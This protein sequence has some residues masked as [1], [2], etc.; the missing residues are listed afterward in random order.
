M[1]HFTDEEHIELADA[2][3]IAPVE[4]DG[5][6]FATQAPR[7]IRAAWALREAKQRQKW[8]E[9]RQQGAHAVASLEEVEALHE[10]RL[11]R[12][13]AKLTKTVALAA[14]VMPGG[15]VEARLTRIEEK[16]AELLRR[17]EPA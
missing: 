15:S 4:K 14:T 2:L 16:L 1:L 5:V 7:F 8:Q 13:E 3:G 10:T 12:I 17:T 9:R 6:A 11:A